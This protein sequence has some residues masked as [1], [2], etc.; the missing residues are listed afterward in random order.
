[1][2]KESRRGLDQF[3]DELEGKLNQISQ[4]RS[5]KKLK[6]KPTLIYQQRCLNQLEH[7]RKAQKNNGQ[8]NHYEDVKQHNASPSS[9][10]NK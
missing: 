8:S 2:M 1:M 4:R 6:I 7:S 9:S 5:N 10:S 3:E